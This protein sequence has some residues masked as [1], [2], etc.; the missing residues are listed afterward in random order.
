MTYLKKYTGIL[1][2][3]LLII[4]KLQGGIFIKKIENISYDFYQSLFIEE[5]DF[6]RVM[7]IDIDEKSIAELGQFPWRRDIWGKLYIN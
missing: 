6:E 4:F 5:T 3:L 7:I 1:L 2:L